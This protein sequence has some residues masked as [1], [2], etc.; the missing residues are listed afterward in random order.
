MQLWKS[1]H[2]HTPPPLNCY[3]ASFSQAQTRTCIKG[4]PF[5]RV[6]LSC[7]PKCAF[8]FSLSLLLT[9]CF[10]FSKRNSHFLSK[11][12]SWILHYHHQERFW[13]GFI[14][15]SGLCPPTP[16]SGHIHISE[17]SPTFPGPCQA[18]LTIRHWREEGAGSKERRGYL[19][20]NQSR[21]R[22]ICLSRSGYSAENNKANPKR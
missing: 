15:L 4:G 19:A 5:Y 18:L 22:L 1:P 2:T 17:A 16:A 7:C 9:S 21:H 12:S 6:F 20:E 10:C 13:V 3:F 8:F 14:L 11:L